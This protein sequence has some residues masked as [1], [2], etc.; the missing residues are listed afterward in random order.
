MII[1]SSQA[2]VVMSTEFDDTACIMIM[3][4]FFVFAPWPYGQ[5]HACARARST[6]KSRM[7]N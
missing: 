1:L 4:A 5:L 7:R 6:E 2:Y 3:T